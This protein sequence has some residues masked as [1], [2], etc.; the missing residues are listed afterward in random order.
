M[1]SNPIKEMISELVFI[2]KGIDENSKIVFNFNP[3][4]FCIHKIPIFIFIF[5]DEHIELL[6]LQ[7]FLSG[8]SGNKYPGW[9]LVTDKFVSRKLLLR[10]SLF[11][12]T[13]KASTKF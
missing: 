11:K 13:F 12:I 1:A 3:F 7:S 6:K 2:W 8:V 5:Y 4:S 9:T 10:R